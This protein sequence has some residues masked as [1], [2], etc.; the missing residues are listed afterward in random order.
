MEYQGKSGCGQVIQLIK[1]YLQN[2]KGHTHCQ[3]HHSFT[4]GV[5]VLGL[6]KSEQNIQFAKYN[7]TQ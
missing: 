5:D 7:I 4:M 1:S 3:H 6:L 2:L